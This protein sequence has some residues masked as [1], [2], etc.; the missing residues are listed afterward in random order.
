M[1]HQQAAIDAQNAA[2]PGD[3]KVIVDPVTGEK[4]TYVF[5]NSGQIIP[6]NEQKKKPVPTG[7]NKVEIGPGQYIYQDQE[8]KTINPKHIVDTSGLTD[9]QKATQGQE[10]AQLKTEQ[11][12]LAGEVAKGNKKPGPDWW[13]WS[14]SNETKLK[15]ITKQL[16]TLQGGAQPQPY[17]TPQSGPQSFAQPGGGPMAPQPAA[18][19]MQYKTKEAVQ[20]AFKAGQLSREEAIKI[21]NTQFGYQ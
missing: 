8:G 14:E 9:L 4:T 20:A 7:I 13:P 16:N 11:A 6:L 21:L 17:A 3:T 18:A 1:K 10:A 15:G 5:Q 19:A 2:K 12:R